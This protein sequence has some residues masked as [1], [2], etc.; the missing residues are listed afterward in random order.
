MSERLGNVIVDSHEAGVER[1]QFLKRT[2]EGP[3]VVHPAGAARQPPRGEVLYDALAEAQATPV[4]PFVPSRRRRSG[5][6]GLA[7][8]GRCAGRCWS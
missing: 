5:R 4:P 1:I 2:H 6:R 3:I 8:G 7:E